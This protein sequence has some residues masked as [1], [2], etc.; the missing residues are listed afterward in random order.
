MLQ[1]RA[2]TYSR[3]ENT[4]AADMAEQVPAAL[5]R[6]RLERLLEVQSGISLERNERHVGRTMRALVD[7]VEEDGTLVVRTE[8]QALEVDGVTL[9]SASGSRTRST[10][11]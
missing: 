6:E 8:G 9:V 7:R 2:F 1:S 11:T 10:T 4:R 3:E 5:M